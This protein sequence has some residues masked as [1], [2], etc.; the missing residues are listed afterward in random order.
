MMRELVAVVAGLGWN[1]SVRF[2]MF[3][4]DPKLFDAYHKGFASQAVDWPR[5][6][7]DV[8][9]SY[10]RK[11]PKLLE[12]GDFGCGEARLSAT[13][14]GVAGS[15][16]ESFAL[17]SSIRIDCV[18]ITTTTAFIIIPPLLQL[19]LCVWEFEVQRRLQHGSVE[20]ASVHISSYSVSY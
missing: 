18:V 10:L 5:N 13:L 2:K 16:W 6:P 9:I 8:C 17:I 3:Q 20:L 15:E 14:N 19:V 11:H 7:L 4:E 12:I 1:C